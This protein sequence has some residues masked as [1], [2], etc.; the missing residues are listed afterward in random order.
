M[1][2]RCSPG[3][4]RALLGAGAADLFNQQRI[5]TPI[6]IV[7][8]NTCETT[9]DY[10]SNAID[11]DGSFRDI[12][13]DD[14][15]RLIVTRNRSILIAR[16]KFTVQRKKQIA[17]RLRLL[18]DR[19]DGPMDLVAAGHEHQNIGAVWAAIERPCS[20]NVLRKR[21]CCNFPHRRRIVSQAPREIFNCDGVC[22]SFRRQH[23]ARLQVFLQR[24]GVECRRHHHNEKVGAGLFLNVESACQSDI[25]I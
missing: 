17:A 19:I 5:D 6:R 18:A 24:A 4:A 7:T 15:F 8:R 22:P 20:V 10:Q 21:L 25:S 13:C 9:V 2:R 16:R 3:A 12:G 11:R 23:D 1:S 14:D